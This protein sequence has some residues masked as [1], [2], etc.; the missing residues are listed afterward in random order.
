MNSDSSFHGE[1][2]PSPDALLASARAEALGKLKIYLGAAPGVGKTYE[3]LMDAR[4]K[5]LAGV[6]IVAGIVETH[7]RVETLELCD[8]LTILP[9]RKVEYKGRVLE[10]MDLDG[11]LRRRPAIALVDE[12]AHSNA[13]GARHPRRW[14]DVEELIAAGIDVWTTLNIQH[15]ESL[16]D[17]VARITRVRVRET[18]PDAILERADEI[19]LIDLTPDQ[20]IERLREGKVYAPD[21]AKRALR[22]YFAPGNLSALR[23]L[24]MRR[25]ADRIDVQVRGFRQAQGETAP[26]AA[27][28]RILVCVN[29]REAAA[30][31]V[32]HAKRL[33]DRARASW[34][35]VHVRTARDTGFS[36]VERVRLNEALRLATRLGAETATLPGDRVAD[37]ILSYAREQNVTQIVIGRAKS[38]FLSS[39]LRS[40]VAADLIA[41]AET[42]AV[43]ILPE[44]ALSLGRRGP[45]VF[46]PSSALTPIGLAEA[47]MLTGAGIAVAVPLD[48]W[49]SVPNLGLVFLAP[50]LV[51]ALRRG[52]WPALIA[53]LFSVLAYDFFFT[54]PRLNFAVHDPQAI[55]SLIVFAAAAVIVSA[56][57]S[58]ARDQTLAARTEARTSRELLGLARGL[59]AVAS[60][61]EVSRTL[62]AYTARAFD[63]DCAVFARVGVTGLRLAATAPGTPVLTDADRA[64]VQWT[65]DK[66]TP[67]GKGTDTLGGAR[68]LFVPLRTTRLFSGVLAL[69]RSNELDPA[70]R[71]RLDAMADQGASAM[72]RAHIARA[73][74][75]ARTEMD[76]EKLR[77]TMLAS[78]SHDLKTPIAGILGSVSSLRAYGARHDP[79]TQ[80]ELLAGIESEADRMQRYVV[81]LLDMMRLDAGGAQPRLQALEV[82][83]V[84]S[85]VVKRAAALA[86]GARLEVD[87]PH[88]LPM[89][90]ADETFLH[91]ALLNLLENA[92]VHGG[93]SP[94]TLRVR[95]R[96]RGMV[97]EVLDEG[98]GF[99]PGTEAHAFDKFWRGDNAPTGGSGLGL[100]IVKGFAGLMGAIV[101][102]S[103]RRDGRGAM[104]SLVFPPSAVLS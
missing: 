65:M 102:A 22:H 93:K 84:V 47:A 25:A 91:Q 26:W 86:D 67:A 3:M 56:L 88:D 69:A 11:L 85:G 49:L 37:T 78:L 95:V 52:L 46:L 80:A 19:E 51:T 2:R 32:R 54:E 42:I 77:A 23:E 30:E 92:I 96:D 6:D 66:G 48:H 62:A 97:F 98:P 71:R 50:V 63:G 10:D 75:E 21:Q 81:K 100:P 87:V 27:G 74:E 14:M 79:E 44:D 1:N 36:E 58:R 24:A 57:A 72:E 82:S 68:W 4:K 73:F 15:V 59:A 89:L 9:R 45:R 99:G 104:L 83:D 70:E 13:P 7:G 18:V 20:L 5:R 35:A 94:V 39:V 55:V 17:V 41:R 33:A 60:E 103:N 64:A 40:S 34:I 31:V 101:V 61:D 28:E 38:T 43:H 8:G 53:A 29:E 16:N 76:A 12:L 90:T